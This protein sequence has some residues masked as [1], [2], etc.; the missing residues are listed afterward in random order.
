[1]STPSD[2]SVESVSGTSPS[3]TLEDTA[4]SAWRFG[5]PPDV[6]AQHVTIPPNTSYGRWMR[7]VRARSVSP[8]PRRT[9][10]SSSLSVA[11]Q[12]AQTTEWKAE[13]ALSSAGI[14]AD[15]TIRTQSTAEDAIAEVRV[16]REEVS[17]HMAEI[18][19]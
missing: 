7:D 4:S 11:Q 8:R 18:S 5:P 13:S 1:M 2:K 17:S 6:S 16:V 3:V 9:I 19:R 15:W 12:R 14:I 10:L